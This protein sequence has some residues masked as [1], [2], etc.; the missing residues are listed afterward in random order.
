MLKYKPHVLH[1]VRENWLQL[2]AHFN[3][4]QKKKQYICPNHF[5]QSSFKGYTEKPFLKKTATPSE[6]VCSYIISIHRD[7]RKPQRNVKQIK[8]AIA[9]GG[10]ELL[11]WQAIASKYT[12]LFITNVT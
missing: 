3:I 6:N 12:E 7:I 11:F 2:L 10:F 1:R 4:D 9:K 5:Q 8:Y